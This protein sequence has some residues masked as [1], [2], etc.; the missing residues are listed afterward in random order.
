MA[1]KLTNRKM[2]NTDYTTWNMAMKQKTW[3]M[4][5]THYRTWNMARNYEKLE[6]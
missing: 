6:K 4:K 5:N 2:R 1:R 3:K